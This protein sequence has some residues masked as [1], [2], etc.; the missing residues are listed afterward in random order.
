MRRE[1]RLGAREARA[2]KRAD[3][4]DDRLGLDVDPRLVETGWHNHARRHFGTPDEGVVVDSHVMVTKIACRQLKVARPASGQHHFDDERALPKPKEMRQAVSV[5][6][7]KDL[8]FEEG[9]ISQ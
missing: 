8:Q 2:L 6:S 9:C 1:G 5:Q 4:S 3:G 7:E